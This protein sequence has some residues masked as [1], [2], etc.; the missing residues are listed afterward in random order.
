MNVVEMR[1]A[2]PDKR[3]MDQEVLSGGIWFHGCWLQEDQPDYYFFGCV[4]IPCCGSQLRK[5]DDGSHPQRRG[6]VIHYRYPAHGGDDHSG[7]HDDGDDGDDGH[8][9]LPHRDG[10]GQGYEPA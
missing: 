2:F 5:L 1:N 9:Q 10:V 3:L 6:L 7:Y 8:Y 4:Q